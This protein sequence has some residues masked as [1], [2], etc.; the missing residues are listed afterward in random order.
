MI[1][2]HQV[3]RTND[4]I[5]MSFYFPGQWQRVKAIY[6]AIAVRCVKCV[7]AKTYTDLVPEADIIGPMGDGLYKY[8]PACVT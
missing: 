2:L 8:T 5:A 4:R 6:T 1:Y 7:I 3:W